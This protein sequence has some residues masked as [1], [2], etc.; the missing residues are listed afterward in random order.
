LIRPN[1]RTIVG[2]EQAEVD[3]LVADGYA[4]VKGINNSTW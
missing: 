2:P 3:A 1:G 4:K